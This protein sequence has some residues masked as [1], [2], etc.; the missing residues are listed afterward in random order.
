MAGVFNDAE[1]QKQ[2]GA[3]FKADCQVSGYALCFGE[4]EC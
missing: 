2:F 4:E 3:D 1:C